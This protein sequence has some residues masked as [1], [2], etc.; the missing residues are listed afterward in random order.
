MRALEARLGL[1]GQHVP[2]HVGED[3]PSCAQPVRLRFYRRVVEVKLH[4]LAERVRLAHEEIGA[5]GGVDEAIRPLRISGVGDDPT[6]ILDAQRRRWRPARVNDRIGRDRAG[7]TRMACPSISSMNSTLN[8][9]WT[10]LEP[11]K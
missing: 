3:D 2:A 7:P 8:F 6:S 5:S 11:G 9:R 1:P 4:R 10:E